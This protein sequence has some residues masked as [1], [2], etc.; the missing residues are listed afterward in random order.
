M[1]DSTCTLSLKEAAEQRAELYAQHGKSLEKEHRREFVA[2]QPDGKIIVDRD[3]LIER[4][5]IELILQLHL[6]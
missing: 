2:I 4:A 6:N 5:R 1:G 3:A